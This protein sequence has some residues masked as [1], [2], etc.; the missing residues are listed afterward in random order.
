SNTKLVAMLSLGLLKRR[1]WLVLTAFA[2]FRMWR[3]QYFQ[4][5]RATFKRDLMAALIMY[6]VK[7]LMQKRVPANQPVHEIWLERVR[8]HPHK[9]AAIEVETGR[10]VT[11]QQ[12]NQLMN[13]YANYFA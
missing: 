9:E 6:R 2:L 13:T 3:S 12:L 4:R 1:W 10:T 8:E 5:V 11:Y 7:R